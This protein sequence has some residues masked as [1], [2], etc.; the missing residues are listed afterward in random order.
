M[1][2]KAVAGVRADISHLWSSADTLNENKTE[3]LNTASTPKENYKNRL[4]REWQT[5]G[6]KEVRKFQTNF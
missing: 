4:V 2:F 5:L 1:V 6:L 3:V